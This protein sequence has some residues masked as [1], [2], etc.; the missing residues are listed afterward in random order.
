M[1]SDLK[2]ECA[3][4]SR[5]SWERKQQLAGTCVVC[6]RPRGK[7]RWLCALHLTAARNFSERDEG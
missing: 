3:L 7:S 6:G 1:S 5:E 4:T 2:L